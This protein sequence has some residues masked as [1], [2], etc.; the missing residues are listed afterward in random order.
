MT[1]SP[2]PIKSPSRV[3]AAI[4]RG[5]SV[6]W[7]GCR[8]V[9]IRPGSPMVVRK[10]DVTLAAA[11]TRIRSWFRMI[12]DAAA[13]IS[14][15]SPGAI[16]ESRSAASARG[17]ISNS[18]S[19]NPPTVRWA[20][21]ANA[22]R[23]WVSTMSRVTSSDSYGTRGSSRN[24]LS[25]TSASCHAAAARSASDSAAQ[26]ASSSPDRRG[27]AFAISSTRPSNS[28]VVPAM[29]WWYLI[30]Y[31][32]P[33][34]RGRASWSPK[35][36]FGVEEAHAERGRGRRRASTAAAGRGRR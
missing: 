6:G 3:A 5:S 11:A 32:G 22:A 23:S 8:R 33:Q 31:S 34:G 15:V 13:T 7:L 25:G 17:A 2:H 21:S 36:R 1:A 28:W 26:P 27:V 14:G 35:S 4:P 12:F 10:A 29:V 24:R 16:R 19:R 18:Q 30:E 9:A 20:I